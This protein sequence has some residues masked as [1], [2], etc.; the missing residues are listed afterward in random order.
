[1]T[2][3]TRSDA[4]IPAVAEAAREAAREQTGQ[5][6]VQEHTAPEAELAAPST[7]EQRVAELRQH[8]DEVHREWKAASHALAEEHLSHAIET[9]PLNAAAA[10]FRYHREEDTLGFHGLL[11]AN[12]E[13]VPRTYAEEESFRQVAEWADPHDLLLGLEQ[14]GGYATLRLDKDGVRERIRKLEQAWSDGTI[15]GDRAAA[16]IDI[17][18]NRYLR[19]VATEQGFQSVEIEPDPEWRSYKAVTVTKN[20][21]SH[22]AGSGDLDD[23]EILWAVGRIDNPHRYATETSAGR[24]TLTFEN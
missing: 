9:T 2:C 1:M 13:W 24:F 5:F 10:R 8:F 3:M 23:S 18:V 19:Q 21:K 11:D 12:G 16:D 20:G 22:T 6:G 7:R 4:H 14:D 17:A 15:P